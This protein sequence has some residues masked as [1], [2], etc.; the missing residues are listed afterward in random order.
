MDLLQFRQL[1]AKLKR[2]LDEQERIDNEVALMEEFKSD[3][4][5][6]QSI[7]YKDI[8]Y[9]HLMTLIGK[10][11]EVG[12][13]VRF[14]DDL[15][16][17]SEEHV[18]RPENYPVSGKMSEQYAKVLPTDAPYKKPQVVEVKPDPELEPEPEIIEDPII[19]E[20]PIEEKPDPDPEEEKSIED[21]IIEA[22]PNPEELKPPDKNQNGVLE[23]E[24]KT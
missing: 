23:G 22:E 16:I 6:A 9:P 1:G 2:V 18:V 4:D 12:D 8:L 24:R 11:V 15:Y 3:L 10:K 17:V 19:E 5:G 14:G 7:E 20:P 21:P 13:K